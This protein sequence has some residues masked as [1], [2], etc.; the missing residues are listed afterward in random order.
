MANPKEMNA[1]AKQDGI[2][3]EKHMAHNSA[4]EKGEMKMAR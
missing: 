3:Y 1:N 2:S 4:N